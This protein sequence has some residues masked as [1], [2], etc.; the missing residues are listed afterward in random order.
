[1][2][3]KV[4]PILQNVPAELRAHPQ[5]CLWS[6]VERPG[7]N[8]A[9][10]WTKL[11]RQVSGRPASSTDPSTWNSYEA[12]V[13]AY[14]EGWADGIGYVLSPERRETGVDLD[15]AFDPET[16]ELHTWAEQHV[17]ELATYA[18]LSPSGHGVRL[19]IR[20][21]LPEEMGGGRRVG[22]WGQDERGIVE[23]YCRARFV[24]V[25]GRRLADTPAELAEGGD[26]FT[27]WCRATFPA[28]DRRVEAPRPSTPPPT[29]ELSDAELLRKMLQNRT[30]GTAIQ[31]L[32]D[33]DCSRN[34]G[35]HSSADLALCNHLAWWCAGRI[36][37]MDRLF[38]QSKL[39]RE[40]WD[41]K[42]GDLTYGQMTLGYAAAD[43][44]T[45]A[46][47]QPQED[48]EQIDL[49]DLSLKDLNQSY[50]PEG[51]PKRD[52]ESRA[53][54]Q[55]FKAY[56]PEHK[57]IYLPTGDL[58]PAAS[59]NGQVPMI[60]TGRRDEEGKKI[61]EAASKWLDRE[62]AVQQM[63]WAPGLPPLVSDQL[64][65][66]GGWVERPGAC[67]YNLYRPPRS[68]EGN[69]KEITPW[70]RHL[71]HIYGEEQARHLLFWFAHRAQRPGEK[72]NHAIVLGGPQGIGKDTILEPLKLAVGPW[73]WSEVSPAEILGRFN[74]F[75]KSVVIRV[76]EAR[77]MGD[78]DR[79]GFYEH[80]KIYTAAPP[81]TLR[82]DEKNRQE[83]VVPNVCGVI[84][85]TNHLQGGIFL[86]ADDRRH[87]VVYSEVTKDDFTA[88]YWRELWTW[89]DAVG[90]AN[91]AAYLR[92]VDLSQFDAKTP[93]PKTDAFYAIVNANRS[94]ED[95]ELDD[96]LVYLGSPVAISKDDLLNGAANLQSYDFKTWMEDRKNARKLS[97]RLEAAGY[98]PV[99]N[100]DQSD[101]R[102]RRGS[103]SITI[104]GRQ[105]LP[106]RDRLV[107]ARGV[108]NFENQ[109]QTD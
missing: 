35:D 76:S 63:T 71:V 20:G 72:I 41:E 105:D 89:Y 98:V 24:T 21:T 78:V 104:W 77:D 95:A 62:A 56:L 18:E 40:K 57:Y 45:G 28:R 107:A 70:W 31:A 82:V 6:Y 4:K 101:G 25:T 108:L 32:F 9:T 5:W 69:P 27:T 43:L 30:N 100:P 11:P 13:A 60:D 8:G 14:Q 53:S 84:L 51:K 10:Y 34:N 26:S 38:R 66:E 52:I 81:D 102:W 79:Y 58:W 86:P 93:P 37:Q 12:V 1:M 33:G 17:R 85:T 59:V 42:R 15:H 109:A 75:R 39:M 64:I 54:L 48:A 99:R 96:V 61:K 65:I 74:G 46:G 50:E 23:A 7:K 103:S 106:V 22:G 68:G 44:A 97:H 92:E 3:P 2:K 36:D 88:D 19:F 90:R 94:P 83:Y 49:S 47:Y 55:D 73:N 87:Y 16:G 67:V 29:L 91:V 80:L